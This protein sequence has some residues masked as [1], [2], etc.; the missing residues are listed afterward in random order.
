[1]IIVDDCSTDGSYEKALEY[2]KKYDRIKVVRMHKNSGTAHARNKGIELSRG[3]YLAFLDSDDVWLP[4]K[5]EKQIHFMLENNYDF[6]FTEYEH[7]NE[8]GTTIDSSK[9]NKKANL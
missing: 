1:M 2:A 5:L 6:T 3:G 4:E 8:D 9:G 7:I